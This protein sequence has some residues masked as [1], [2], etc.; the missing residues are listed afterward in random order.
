MASRVLHQRPFWAFASLNLLAAET[1]ALQ[2]PYTAGQHNWQEVSC[3]QEKK[4]VN[5]V[6]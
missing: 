4:R 2:S 6:N 3:I 5:G 1:L